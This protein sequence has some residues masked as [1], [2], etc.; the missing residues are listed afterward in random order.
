MKNRQADPPPPDDASHDRQAQ[1]LAEIRAAIRLLAPLCPP[2]LLDAIDNAVETLEGYHRDGDRD[3]HHLDGALHLLAGRRR[4]YELMA[5]S[6]QEPA[7]ARLR[8][9]LEGW[10]GAITMQIPPEPPAVNR[11]AHPPHA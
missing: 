5:G 2:R 1:L 4:M 6:G 10:I 9:L 7:D 11:A 8:D 3:T